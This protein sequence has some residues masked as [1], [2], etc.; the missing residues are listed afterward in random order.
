MTEIRIENGDNKVINAQKGIFV[1]LDAE[2]NKIMSM[3]GLDPQEVVKLTSGLV[4]YAMMK[5]M[6]DAML[7]GNKGQ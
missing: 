4:E 5:V 2:G 1:G 7:F 6:V 3:I